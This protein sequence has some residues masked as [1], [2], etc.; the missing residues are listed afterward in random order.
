M[1]AKPQGQNSATPSTPVTDVL[2]ARFLSWGKL[3]HERTESMLHRSLR[4]SIAI[5]ATG[6]VLLLGSAGVAAAATITGTGANN[7]LVG[8]ATTDTIDGLAGN[9]V[10][11]GKA[12]NDFL[13]GG[14]GNDIIQ[15]GTGDDVITAGSGRDLIAGG[16]GDDTINLGPPDGERDIV[17]CGDGSKDKVTGKSPTDLISSSCE[18][19]S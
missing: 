17:D 9:D 6:T 5:A 19:V 11:D 4:R 3:T 14:L 12:G 16:T 7:V 8:T 10:I 18:T 2:T 1:K 15:G 13:T